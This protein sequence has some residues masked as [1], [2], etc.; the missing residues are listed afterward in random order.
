MG[1][2]YDVLTCELIKIYFTL[3]WRDNKDGPILR[4]WIDGNATV[5]GYH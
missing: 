3:N 5:A 4:Q 2:A 1:N